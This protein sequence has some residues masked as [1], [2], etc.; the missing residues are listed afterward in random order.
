M[1]AKRKSGKWA[2]DNKALRKNSKGLLDDTKNLLY[3]IDHPDGE[4]D[5]KL[6]SMLEKEKGRRT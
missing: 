5:P 3:C 1:P 2:N 4:P 6:R